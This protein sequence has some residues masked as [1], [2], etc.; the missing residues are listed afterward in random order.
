MLYRHVVGFTESAW[1]WC[2]RVIIVFDILDNEKSVLA[3]DSKSSPSKKRIII[4]TAY[5][6]GRGGLMNE[7]E[8]ECMNVLATRDIYRFSSLPLFCSRGRGSV[9]WPE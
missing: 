2:G 1:T 5:H 6:G 8:R 4:D 7:G 3:A 9:F